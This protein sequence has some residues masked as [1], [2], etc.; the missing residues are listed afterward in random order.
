MLKR[1]EE[2]FLLVNEWRG[3]A[4]T[5][6]K[7]KL[8]GLLSGGLFFCMSF[9]DFGNVFVFSVRVCMLLRRLVM[10]QYKKEKGVFFVRI[11]IDKA[12]TLN[13]GFFRDFLCD[14]E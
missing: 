4:R 2:R 6:N 7:K 13:L 10:L 1:S 11:T 8:S 3:F 9:T 14:I 5:G 12:K